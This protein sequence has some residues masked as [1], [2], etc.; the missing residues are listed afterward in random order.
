M[1]HFHPAGSGL[2]LYRIRRCGHHLPGAT[3]KRGE[4]RFGRHRPVVDLGVPGLAISLFVLAINFL[5]DGLR[6]FSTPSSSKEAAVWITEK[7][8]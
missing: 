4:V 6:T 8:H 7:S 1:W 2:V 5:G 3:S